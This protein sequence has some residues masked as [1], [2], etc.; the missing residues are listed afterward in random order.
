MMM[1]MM[2]SYSV[3]DRSNIF[4]SSRQPCLSVSTLRARQTDFIESINC[5]SSLL[6]TIVF[7]S[8]VVIL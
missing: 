2:T 4:V 3:S 5:F 6:Y 1:M 8:F 7:V